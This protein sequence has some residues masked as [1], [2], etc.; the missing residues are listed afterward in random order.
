MIVDEKRL[1]LARELQSELGRATQAVDPI[2]ILKALT[3]RR[4]R[5][6]SFAPGRNYRVAVLA[7]SPEPPSG[8]D[9][10]QAV[11][12][13][14]VPTIRAGMVVEIAGTYAG[15]INASPTYPHSFR[16]LNGA[17]ATFADMDILG[18]EKR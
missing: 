3:D 7:A 18:W 5:K 9:L 2:A 11:G 10:D 15:R 1:E 17:N 4:I 12:M 13:G 8:S 6:V 14:V 16:M